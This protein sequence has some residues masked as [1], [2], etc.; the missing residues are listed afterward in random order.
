MNLCQSRR[1]LGGQCNK[2]QGRSN[3]FDGRV[4]FNKSHG[5]YPAAFFFLNTALIFFA[6][7]KWTFLSSL[8]KEWLNIHKVTNQLARLAM[9][10]MSSST[11]VMKGRGG[12]LQ[13]VSQPCEAAKLLPAKRLTASL[14]CLFSFFKAFSTLY[15]HCHLVLTPSPQSLHPS[16]SSSGD[17]VQLFDGVLP[18]AGESHPPG[19]G[20][21]AA[22]STVAVHAHPGHGGGAAVVVVAWRRVGVHLDHV[23][24]VHGRRGADVL[25]RLG[26]LVVTEPAHGGNHPASCSSLASSDHQTHRHQ[27]VLQT[28]RGD[29]KPLMGP[30]SKD[31]FIL[32][33]IKWFHRPHLPAMWL[34]TSLPAERLRVGAPAGAHHGFVVLVLLVL[35]QAG[36]RVAL[37]EREQLVLGADAARRPVEGG[38]GVLRLCG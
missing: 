36:Q 35:G 7:F 31:S 21:A 8:Y 38:A 11:A 19:V 13:L 18:L 20:V 34:K 28:V 29:Q 1:G 12:C 4:S 23:V 26:L 10:L 15:S 17:E 14:N 24:A 37:P 9:R 32:S 16:A 3:I 5:E 30:G 33:D 22:A 6:L 2:T 25:L 27:P